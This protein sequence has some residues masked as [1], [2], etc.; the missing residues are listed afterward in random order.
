MI[1]ALEVSPA[2]SD[3]VFDPTAQH[4]LLGSDK[5]G[6]QLI[7]ALH[8]E[9]LSEGSG[10]EKLAEGSQRG[11]EGGHGTVGVQLRAAGERGNRI[12]KKT[13]S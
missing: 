1:K 8:A 9:M 10:D 5:G 4:L 13:G 6:R 12:Y 11:S 2:T 3:R 7:L